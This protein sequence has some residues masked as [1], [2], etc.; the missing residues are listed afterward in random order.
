MNIFRVTIEKPMI[1]DTL[2]VGKNIDEAKILALK[3]IKSGKLDFD[4]AEEGDVCI[5]EYHRI[6]LTDKIIKEIEEYG[7]V[8]EQSKIVY[9]PSIYIK[10]VTESQKKQQ[11]EEGN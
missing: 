7:I 9:D 1:I 4:Y 5:A 3:C 2:V 8:N 10:E 11:H 6:D